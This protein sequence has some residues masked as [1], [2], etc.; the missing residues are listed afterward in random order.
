VAN[1]LIGI[2]V[3]CNC[4]YAPPSKI[5]HP[6]KKECPDA[7]FG[8]PDTGFGTPDACFGLPDTYFGI[9]ISVFG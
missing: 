1:P 4:F 3:C 7:S 6:K 9:P 5:G 2:F 8:L